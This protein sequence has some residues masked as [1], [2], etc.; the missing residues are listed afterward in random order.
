MYPFTTRKPITLSVSPSI[1]IFPFFSHFA[2]GVL[3]ACCVHSPRRSGLPRWILAACLFLSVMVMLWLSCA[4]LVTAPEQHIKNQVYSHHMHTHTHTH[5]YT[6]TYIHTHTHT[7]AH[8]H[9]CTHA[10]THTHT[11]T[12]PVYPHHT[13]LL[14]HITHQPHTHRARCHLHQRQ[15]IWTMI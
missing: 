4:S 1:N 6:H 15:R 12:Q 7:H 9:I 11:H 3:W 8:I 13:Q 14:H 2:P 10:R 5:T